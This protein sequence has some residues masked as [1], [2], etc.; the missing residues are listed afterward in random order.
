VVLGCDATTTSLTASQFA[1]EA[2]VSRETL[3][4]LERYVALLRDWQRRKNLVAPSTLLDPWRRHLLDS[5][6]LRPLM[7]ESPG[8]I[9]DLGTG[10]GFPG[11]VLATMGVPRI[12]LIESDQGK[13]RFLEAVA[14][15]V[16]ADVIIHPHR[17]EDLGKGRL[18]GAV[19]L[20][21]S[22][23]TAPLPR[24]LEYAAPLLAPR[25]VALLHKGAKAEE[26]LT[27]AARDWIMAV[28]RL[29]SRS[30]P[31]GVILRLSDIRR[32]RR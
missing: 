8:L 7:P 22:R 27:L 5:A 6:Q 3:E 18:R 15:E 13:C 25:A 10:A 26:E 11:M 19:R 21:L 17:A 14:R 29:P 30:D 12:H 20:L 16:A 23:A 1:E 4:R 32:K 24:L 31:R 28:E 9:A 2:G